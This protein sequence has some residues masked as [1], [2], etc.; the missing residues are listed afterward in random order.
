MSSYEDK[1]LGV[2]HPISP[3]QYSFLLVEG[4]PPDDFTYIINF[5]IFKF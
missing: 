5:V 3:D 2:I 1:S 4:V